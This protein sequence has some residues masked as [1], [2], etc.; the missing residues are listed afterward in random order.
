MVTIYYQ[1]N[2]PFQDAHKAQQ[3]LEL[4]SM[5]LNHRDLALQ[6]AQKKSSH[7]TLITWPYLNGYPNCC[8]LELIVLVLPFK[9]Q[10]PPLRIASGD[11]TWAGEAQ[12]CFCNGWCPGHVTRILAS[13]GAT[14][15]VC[16]SIAIIIIIIII[17]ITI[18]TIIIIMFILSFFRITKWSS[19]MPTLP[20]L[21]SANNHHTCLISI[22]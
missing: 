19:S 2:Q 13:C 8:S 11:A 16:I 5:L 17:I 9:K 1:H 7:M 22:L 15:A 4:H 10:L 6:Q 12:C 3:L 18:I 14:T 21:L 20:L